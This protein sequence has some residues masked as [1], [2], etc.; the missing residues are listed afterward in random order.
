MRK[1][2]AAALLAF[3]GTGAMA[4]T[5]KGTMAVAG[6]VNFRNETIGN[7]SGIADEHKIT[8]RTININPSV[9]Y[10][11]KDGLE[12]GLGICF[13]RFSSK[14]EQDAGGTSGRNLNISFRPYAR[15]Y[16]VLA[17]Q[18]QLHGTGYAVVGFGNSKFR[19]AAEDTE[20]VT[21]TSNNFGFG[22]YPGLTYFATP[23]LG[24]TATFG[25]LSFS[26]TTDKPKYSELSERTTNTFTADLHPS[27]ISIGFGYFIAR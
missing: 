15:K 2:L 3:A 20:E 9:G 14:T 8:N 4:Q 13:S 26:R 16:V 27:S 17:E 7:H 25:S 11:V 5:T 10:F 19:N 22:I 18:L 21:H 6:S 12:M 24:F 1:F 23:K